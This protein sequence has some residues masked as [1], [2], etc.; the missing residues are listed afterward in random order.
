[1]GYGPEEKRGKVEEMVGFQGSPSQSSRMVHTKVEETCMDEQGASDK[2]Q[3]QKEASRC[4]NKV[5]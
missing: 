5:R 2:T 3:T 4:R 1:M